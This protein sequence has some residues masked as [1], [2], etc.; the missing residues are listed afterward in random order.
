MKRG[1]PITRKE[2]IKD[3]SFVYTVELKGGGIIYF[4]DEDKAR[5]TVS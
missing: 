4:T 1:G 3:S 5:Q 2:D